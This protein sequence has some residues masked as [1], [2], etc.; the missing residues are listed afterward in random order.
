MPQRQLETKR[1]ALTDTL[2]DLRGC[3]DPQERLFLAAHLLEHAAELVLLADG[4]WLG[5]GKWL[6]RRLAEADPGLHGRLTEGFAAVVTGADDGTARLA[7]AVGEALA[8]AGG[9]L[10]EGYRRSAEAGWGRRRQR[11]RVAIVLA[12]ARGSVCVVST[13]MS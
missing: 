10:W 2:H 4:R 3:T 12:Q 5:A 8:R 9:P 6:S 1:Y 13:S 7:A 11:S